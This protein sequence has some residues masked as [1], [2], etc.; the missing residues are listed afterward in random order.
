MVL[1]ALNLYVMIKFYFISYFNCVCVCFL[2]PY[3]LQSILV[4]TVAQEVERVAVQILL[5]CVHCIAPTPTNSKV[6]EGSLNGP[7]VLMFRRFTRS[8][9]VVFPQFDF[10][11]STVMDGTLFT[12][13]FNSRIIN[14]KHKITSSYYRKDFL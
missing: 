8:L 13:N 14:R 1:R 6:V 5:H 4:A 3:L 2:P 11:D 10:S 12:N 7:K 9:K